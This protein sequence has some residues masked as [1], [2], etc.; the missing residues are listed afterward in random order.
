M[1]VVTMSSH[2][3]LLP[4]A[5][6]P[7]QCD[8]KPVRSS[9]KRMFYC[10]APL[11]VDHHQQHTTRTFDAISAYMRELTAFKWTGTCL[12]YQ[13]AKILLL[14][15]LGCSSQQR[16]MK[17]VHKSP[18]SL[19]V[20]C[21]SRRMWWM[22]WE[23]IMVWLK[24]WIVSLTK[25]LCCWRRK[26][27]ANAMRTR[28][29]YMLFLPLLSWYFDTDDIRSMGHLL[30]VEYASY[31]ARWAQSWAFAIV[32]EQSEQTLC[33]LFFFNCILCSSCYIPTLI[34]RVPV[35]INFFMPSW[36]I[37]HK[38]CREKPPWSLSSWF[39]SNC[40][41]TRA[42]SGRTL[43]QLELCGNQ[44]DRGDVIHTT[45]CLIYTMKKNDFIK[46]KLAPSSSPPPSN[47]FVALFFNNLISTTNHHGSILCA[48][49]Q[50]LCSRIL[51]STHTHLQQWYTTCQFFP[52]VPPNISCHHHHHHLL[53]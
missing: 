3:D 43:A 44:S 2:T 31:R 46:K 24:T 51:C 48:C 19:L 10:C 4:T 50:L 32:V 41:T 49:I 27:E 1:L 6:L 33:A 35:F 21:N 29:Q 42:E 5:R 36:C 47:Y 45:S 15:A 23:W 16:V 40:C 30:L 38:R 37:Q 28:T 13:L 53:C 34:T 25:T 11:V 12:S 39:M 7:H 20:C 9:P 8:H 14:R 18:R 22:R 26:R 17:R 52:A